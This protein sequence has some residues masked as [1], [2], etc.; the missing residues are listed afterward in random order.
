MSG[1]QRQRE[2][3]VLGGVGQRGRSP[4]DKKRSARGAETAAEQHFFPTRTTF[5][6]EAERRMHNRLTRTANALRG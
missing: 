4:P 2:D 3:T 1:A 6:D 5:G